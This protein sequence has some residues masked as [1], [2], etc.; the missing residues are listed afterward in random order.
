MS[1]TSCPGE[2]DLDLRC[3]ACVEIVIDQVK[4]S[5]PWHADRP[6]DVDEIV[7]EALIRI[8]CSTE[9]GHG[10]AATGQGALRTWV[11]TASRNAAT[12]WYRREQ[13]VRRL[14]DQVLSAPKPP[15]EDPFIE[16]EYVRS[17]ESYL[18]GIDPIHAQAVRLAVFHECTNVEIASELGKTPQWWGRKVDQHVAQIARRLFRFG[19]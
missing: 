6:E 5:V 8:V 17:V 11:A 19:P 14:V 13:Q 2:H 18:E 16:I 12:D 1:T 9:R 15:M 10:W 4:R 7:A 3:T